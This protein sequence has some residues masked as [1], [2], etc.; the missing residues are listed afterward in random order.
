V[1]DVVLA[2]ADSVCAISATVGTPDVE[3]SVRLFVD[4]IAAARKKKTH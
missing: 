4:E 1:R 2:G 3:A